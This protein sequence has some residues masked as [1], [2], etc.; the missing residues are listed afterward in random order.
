MNLFKLLYPKKYEKI[1]MLQEEVAFLSSEK[2]S[3]DFLEPFDFVDVDEDGNPHH[4]LK[5]LNPDERKNFIAD[6]ERIYSDERFNLVLKYAINVIANYY[7]QKE[8]D[9]NK[10]R[11]GRYAVIGI[12]TLIKELEK[13][14]T[15]Y[16]ESKKPPDEFNKYEVI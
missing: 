7:F 9:E 16:Q 11:N 13:M 15:E 10:M 8:P 1:E 5:G 14:H 6:M 4:F 12:R 2:T 3:N